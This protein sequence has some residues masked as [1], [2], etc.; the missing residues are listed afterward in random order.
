MSLKEIDKYSSLPWPM[1]MN[2]VPEVSDKF[3]SK[4]RMN[5]IMAL[6]KCKKVTIPH[7]Y[8]SS[9][10]VQDNLF[11]NRASVENFRQCFENGCS[12]ITKG[13]IEGRAP[14][15]GPDDGIYGNIVWGSCMETKNCKQFEES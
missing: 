6:M 7:S 10:G 11:N 12:M 15:T 13:L 3:D 4:N 2:L 5:Y 9:L 14:K 8:Y 1:Y